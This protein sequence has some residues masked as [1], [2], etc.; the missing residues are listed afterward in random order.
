MTLMGTQVHSAPN[1][2]V[3]Q[4]A[5]TAHEAMTVNLLF[6]SIVRIIAIQLLA[7]CYTLL[8]ATS[9][10]NG[11]YAMDH[12]LLY[13]IMRCAAKMIISSQETRLTSV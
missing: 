10:S 13:L 4:L 6:E 7:N 3:T 9:A 2:V 11:A 8:P 5:S 1:A 12:T